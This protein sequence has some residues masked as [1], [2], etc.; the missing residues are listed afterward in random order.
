MNNFRGVRSEGFSTNNGV[1]LIYHVSGYLLC[2]VQSVMPYNT[3]F[4]TN[5]ILTWT[6]N[7]YTAVIWVAKNT[8][9][10]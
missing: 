1:S 10:S 5:H 3:K 6:N 7:I 2:Y 4:M 9:N 8:I